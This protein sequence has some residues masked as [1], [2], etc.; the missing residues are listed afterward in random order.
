MTR[1]I[2]RIV[3]LGL[4]LS[5]SVLAAQPL[6]D[7]GG[8]RMVGSL[9][10]HQGLKDDALPSFLI[11]DEI[12]QDADDRVILTGNAQVRRLD[13]IV[14]GDRIDYLQTTGEADVRGSGLIIRD[15]N[16][17]R[18]PHLRYNVDNDTGLI[19]QPHFWLAGAGGTGKADE[20]EIFSR[21]H[22]RL[23]NLRYTGWTG[24]D[25]AW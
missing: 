25:P 4:C 24:P 6:P 20:A 3:F 9:G 7:A 11:G 18:G 15:G 14:K 17:V 12:R 19:E 2:G 5:A 13:S 23:H 1:W 8:L 16:L 22:M 21:D 10:Q